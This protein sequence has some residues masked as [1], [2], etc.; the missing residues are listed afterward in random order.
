MQEKRKQKDVTEKGGNMGTTKRMGHGSG[1]P[2]CECQQFRRLECRVRSSGGCWA[3]ADSYKEEGPSSEFGLVFYRQ[4][5]ETGVSCM[6]TL[7]FG[8]DQS[9]DSG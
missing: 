9:G 4:N 1:G 2:L 5:R 3:R 7:V 6:I 8:K